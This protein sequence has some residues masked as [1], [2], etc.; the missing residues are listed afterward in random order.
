MQM[1]AAASKNEP[2]AG[3]ATFHPS[4]R[5]QGSNQRRTAAR[6]RSHRRRR[7]SH[8]GEPPSLNPASLQLSHQLTPPAPAGGFATV[9]VHPAP[10]AQALHVREAPQAVALGG[11][12]SADSYLRGDKLLAAARATGAD[13]LHP[14][15]GFL[16]ENA[17]F[18]Q[19]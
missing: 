2:I 12:A 14:G 9:A 5:G 16:S 8:S 7:P 17:D 4:H 18:A 15:Y 1:A 3:H 11:A 19:A 10:A 13:A 6:R